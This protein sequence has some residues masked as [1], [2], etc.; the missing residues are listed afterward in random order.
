MTTSHDLSFAARDIL[1]R[2]PNAT[3]S[4][5]V[6][7]LWREILA[8]LRE[9]AAA[10]GTWLNLTSP[11]ALNL[12]AGELTPASQAALAGWA[13][14]AEPEQAIAIWPA[15]DQVLL[16]VTLW[17]DAGQADGV[18][19]L[20]FPPG[21]RWDDQAAGELRVA[22]QAVAAL[23]HSC[24]TLRATEERLSR[25]QYLYE[26]GQAISSTLE[27]QE[28]L[29]Q[30]TERIADVLQAEASTLMLID[31]ARQELVFTVP[32]GPAQQ[33]LREHRMPMDRGVAGWVATHSQPIIIPDVATDTR[34][35]TA[36]DQVSGFRTRSI[37]A[38]PLQVKGKTI[39]VAEVINKMDG[40]AF[41]T[42]DEQWLSIL[43]PLIAAAIDN[44]RLFAALREEHDRIIAA[45]EKVRHELARDL[46]DGPAQILAALILNVDVAR[47]QLGARPDRMA[48][49][50]NFLE[51]LAQEANHEIR[52][53]LFG[54][55]PLVLETHGLSAALK[56]LVER[57][58]KRA[59]G[60]TNLDVNALPDEAVE[61]GVASTLF[62]IVQEA[63][64]NIH[65]HAQAQNV[66]IRLGA[67]KGNLWVEIED[68][69][70]GF[71]VDK[72]ESSYSERGN[73]GLLNIRER[74]RLIEGSA[75][76][77]SPS[78]RGGRGTL[79]RVEVP[80]QH[81]RWKQGDGA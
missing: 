30:S 9:T 32:A 53:L 72:V 41:S 51:S 37:M 25:F 28:V 6:P 62:V 39:G 81:R 45:E 27:L 42:H 4:S 71:D 63:L 12:Q 3:R 66:T 35:Y 67:N 11:I 13:P 8:G 16:A 43:A 47:R 48:A 76:F 55:R 58:R 75:Q 70:V 34:F 40:S 46:H 77:I 50:L 60:Q 2:L 24:F 52:N 17:G 5:D 36:V 21:A 29:R 80:L 56:Q 64:N 20:A 68:D 10:S 33:I 19:A 14:P 61:P 57:Y 23:G 38:V 22:L 79:V 54:L 69:G 18:V 65:K 15:P 74:A 1:T 44:A 59:H 7:T 73:F 49:E 78:P 31:E 26:V